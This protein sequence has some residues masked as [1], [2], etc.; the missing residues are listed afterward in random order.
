MNNSF[1]ASIIIYIAV[2][3]QLLTFSSAGWTKDYK[4]TQ[5][6][7][8]GMSGFIFE[9]PSFKDWESKE[10]KSSRKNQC[11]IYFNWPP[12]ILYEIAPQIIIEKMKKDKIHENVHSRGTNPNGIHYGRIFDP[13]LYVSGYKPKPDD[14]DWL[15]FYKNNTAIRI[16]R[17]QFGSSDEDSECGKKYNIFNES[18]FYDT[19][20][21]T[22]RWTE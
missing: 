4:T 3:V 12:C 17:N 9:Y 14:W 2:L 19:I 20:I 21:K 22:F 10:V 8:S 6:S 18:L 5:F 1:M 11:F 7:C 13:A 15:I 16:S